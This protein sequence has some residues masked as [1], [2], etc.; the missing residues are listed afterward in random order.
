M[1]KVVS[2]CKHFDAELLFDRVELTLNRGDR[3][4]LV[5][6][7]GAGKTTL[8]RI[9]VGEERPSAGHV[10]RSPG[11]SLGYFGQQV[12]DP[13]AMVGDFLRAGLG[14]ID[15]LAT[16]M[17]S[18]E[19]L[20]AN[21]KTALREYGEVQ[22]RWTALAGWTA[23]HRLAQVR[24]RLDLADL[25]DDVRL[26]ETSGGEQA[27][28]T[29][30]RV[31]LGEPDLL[32]LDEPTNHLDAEGTAWLGEWLSGFPGGVLL[33]SHDR[34][35]LDRTVTE[36]VELDGIHTEPQFYGPF[37]VGSGYSGY[38]AEKD[39]RWSRY[40]L[41]YEAQEKRRRRW[42]ADIE[43]TKDHAV[44]VENTVRGRGS[45]KIRRYA[46]K[47]AK[48]AK[49][50]EG[51][52]R[53]QLDSVRWLAAP[54][55]RPPLTL[56]F[57]TAGGSAAPWALA[58][59]GLTVKLAGR[60]LFRDLDLRVKA[61]DRV[62]LSGRNGTGKTTLLRVLAGELAPDAGTV[63]GLAQLLPQTHDAL[64]TPTTV[65]DFF[66][67]RVP[68]YLDEAEEL[69]AAHQFPAED[70]DAPLRTLSAGELRRL[71]LA[72]MVNSGAEVLLL[73]E[74]TNYLDFDALDVVEEGLGAYQG[75]LIMVTHDTYFAERV[76]VT[77]RWH[78]DLSG[79]TESETAH[80]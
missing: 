43:S 25:P 11:E 15:Q 75:T 62:I 50:R 32:I 47:V 1:L 61:G 41:D 12:A 2:V 72:A 78:L 59:D 68:V 30:A 60:V 63:T 26:I 24:Q 28:L 39:R 76:G 54:E 27:R 67:S 33:V 19:P 36:I 74:P 79:L 17:A 21:S 52:L 34:A 5:G 66:R 77:R 29:L 13:Q 55:T 56:A 10:E 51:R 14:E 65:V 16:A 49:V 42:E 57:A 71:L 44:G 48:K 58:A 8:L 35:F 80:E 45:D 4:G 38:R 73:D 46:K 3:V 7:N 23:G 64:R 40:L 9:L 37:P 70:W 53:R 31:L 69:L 6:P 22:E 20:L 18:L